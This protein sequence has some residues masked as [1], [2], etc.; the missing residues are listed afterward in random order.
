L[1]ALIIKNHGSLRLQS[2]TTGAYISV[3]INFFFPK[4]SAIIPPVKKIPRFTKHSQG[5][6][7]I[8][9]PK[10]PHV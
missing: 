1:G 7:K 4:K 5:F 2:V 3:S 8:P 9:H 10:T 6:Q